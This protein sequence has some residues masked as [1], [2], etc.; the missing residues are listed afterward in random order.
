MAMLEFSERI[1]ADRRSIV[2][3]IVA[4]T[5]GVLA[6]V[7]LLLTF[8]AYRGEGR[9]TREALKLKRESDALVLDHEL[10][11]AQVTL[12]GLLR[13]VTQDRDLRESLAKD[14]AQGISINLEPHYT[15]NSMIHKEV[16]GYSAF[17]TDSRMRIW[18]GA[19]EIAVKDG[20]QRLARQALDQ[21]KQ[22][23]AMTDIGGRPVMALATPVYFQRQV[24]GVVAVCAGFQVPLDNLAQGLDADVQFIDAGGNGLYSF[25]DPFRQP[26]HDPDAAGID[27]VKEGKE[28]FAIS[29]MP[30]T[31]Q[32]GEVLGTVLIRTVMTPFFEGRARSLRSMGLAAC[33]IFLIGSVSVAALL[34]R[35]MRPLQSVVAAIQRVAD[36]DLAVQVEVTGQDEVAQLGHAFNRMAENLRRSNSAL[37]VKAA[38]DGA[39]TNVMV[40]NRDGTVTYANGQ[41]LESLSLLGDDLRTLAPGISA[42]NFVGSN[43]SQFHKD[44]PGV[45]SIIDDVRN[46]PYHG[47]VSFASRSWEVAVNAVIDDQGEYV[48]TVMEW[49]DITERT[50]MEEQLSELVDGVTAGHLEQRVDPE[51]FDDPEYSSLAERLNA[52]LATIATPLMRINQACQHVADASLEIAMGN[53]DLAARTQQEAASVDE[54]SEAAG[55][56]ATLVRSSADNAKHANDLAKEAYAVA[57]EGESVVTQA[58]HAMSAIDQSSMRIRDIIEVID[59]IAFQTNLLSLNAAVEAARAGEHGRGFAVVAA[60]VRNLA[61]R[62]ATAAQEIKALIQDSVGKVGAGTELVNASGKSLHGLLESVRKVTDVVHEIAGAADEQAASV[63]GVNSHLAEI[64]VITQ[65]NAALV[66][67]VAAAAQTLTARAQEMSGEVARFHLV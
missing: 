55:R 49:T 56:I 13:K 16:V 45:R 54:T 51:Q 57:E 29:H 4:T 9:M 30:L 12:E 41:M 14:D 63:D 11:A 53:Q 32:S 10:T 25:G 31:D 17:G 52:M 7:T 38:L 2:W 67:E 58:V 28:S 21:G 59:E 3:P 61:R 37:S 42:A 48:A 60:E 65:K 34:L 24:V 62:S 8:L 22:R 15:R 33:A 18:W 35:R 50:C 43:L 6:V 23:A 20:V 40:A 46:L 44:D 1:G 26:D 19:K 36:G 64:N 66:Q 5:A 39:S 47:K 27:V